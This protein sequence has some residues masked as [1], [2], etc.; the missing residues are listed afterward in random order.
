MLEGRVVIADC[1]CWVIRAYGSDSVLRMHAC[2][3][4]VG[5]TLD[6]LVRKLYLDKVL[7]VSAT[8]EGEESQLFLT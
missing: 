2:S 5:L 8:G 6:S 3:G 1:G 4:H 7:S